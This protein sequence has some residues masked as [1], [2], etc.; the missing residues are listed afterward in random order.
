MDFADFDN[1]QTRQ[2][3]SLTPRQRQSQSTGLTWEESVSNLVIRE[4]RL[5]SLFELLLLQHQNLKKWKVKN[6]EKR[7]KLEKTESPFTAFPKQV[8][9]WKKP[10][11]VLEVESKS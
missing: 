1:D 9:N 10:K 3:N 2:T 11:Q 4:S 6:C 8:V 7:E 5:T